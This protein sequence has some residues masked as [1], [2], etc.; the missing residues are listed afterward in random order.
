LEAN[1]QKKTGAKSELVERCIDG[2]LFGALPK[3]PKCGGGILRVT[4]DAKF[5]H[6][7]K[8]TY[9]CPGYFDGERRALAGKA[10]EK[11]LVRWEKNRAGSRDYGRAGCR[12]ERS[13]G[14]SPNTKWARAHFRGKNTSG[15]M[16][17]G[18]GRCESLTL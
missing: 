16:G 10:K 8:G 17:A 12:K 14:L 6:G 5:G 11:G 15:Q 1:N 3:C 4:Y 18:I 9:T 2:K 13:H 7:G